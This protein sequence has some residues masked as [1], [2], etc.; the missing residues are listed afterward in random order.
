MLSK[1]T[2][3]MN[4]IEEIYISTYLYKINK[5]PQIL[6]YKSSYL[7]HKNLVKLMFLLHHSQPEIQN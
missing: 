4:I 6:D 1:L 2:K 7:F 3:D 5:N